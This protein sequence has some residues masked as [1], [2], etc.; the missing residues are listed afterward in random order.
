[1]IAASTGDRRRLPTLAAAGAALA[2][3]AGAAQ[4]IEASESV[5]VPGEP[6]AVWERIGGFCAISEWHPA[7]ASCEMGE[8]D[9]ATI[10]TLTLEG[11]GTILE[12]RLSE[13]E[14]SYGYAILE[15]PLP[16]AGYTAEIAAEPGEGGTTITW[17]G[18]F[19][20]SGATDEEA[21]AVML[22]IYRA[23]LDAIAA[24]AG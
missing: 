20:A 6:A 18:S 1:M 10:R 23:G 14:A 17:S 22:G 8:R 4:A 9:G 11:G 19:E 12:E 21:E 2:L 3:G 16:V 24:Q 5:S 13:G 7:V 15:S